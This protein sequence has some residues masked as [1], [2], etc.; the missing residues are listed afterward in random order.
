MKRKLIF[1]FLAA[2]FLCLPL[3]VAAQKQNG[4]ARQQKSVKKELCLQLYSVRDL[5]RDINKD[6]KA[7]ARWTSLLSRLHDMG[8]TSVEA[9]WYDQEH[10]TF[11][12][13]KAK[14]FKADVEKAGMKVLSSHVNHVLQQRSL[15]LAISQRLLTGGRNVLLTTRQQA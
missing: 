12:N 8:Y 7:E 3:S 6:G 11:Y 14:Y 4:H 1:S 15:L 10:G 13:R 9:A 2:F 5:V